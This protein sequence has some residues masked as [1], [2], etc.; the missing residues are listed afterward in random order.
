M[1]AWGRQGG[2]D[3]GARGFVLTGN[4]EPELPSPRLRP[5][6]PCQPQRDAARGV[7][8]APFPAGAPSLCCLR[9]LWPWAGSDPR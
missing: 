8:R 6:H 1:R 2:G 9:C 4:G 7:E 3:R 5:D